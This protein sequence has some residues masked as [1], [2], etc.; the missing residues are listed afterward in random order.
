MDF[1]PTRTAVGLFSN[2]LMISE[3]KRAL[4]S[5]TVT[6]RTYSDDVSTG[7]SVFIERVVV[8]APVIILLSTKAILFFFH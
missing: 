5:N 7:V 6:S 3:K 1:G 2:I 8:L 4:L